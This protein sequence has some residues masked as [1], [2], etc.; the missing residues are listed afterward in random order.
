M[1]L[2]VVINFP[3]DIKT[4]SGVNSLISTTIDTQTHTEKKRERKR[5]VTAPNKSGS[6]ERVEGDGGSGYGGFG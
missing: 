3:L 2:S 1:I 5:R 6:A 4:Q